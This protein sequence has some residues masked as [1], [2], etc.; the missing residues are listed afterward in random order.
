MAVVFG[1]LFCGCVIFPKNEMYDG[2]IQ[3]EK[4]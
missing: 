3:Q 1:K 2:V 4:L